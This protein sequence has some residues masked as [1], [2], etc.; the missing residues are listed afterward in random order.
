MYQICD[1]GPYTVQEG[2]Y[3]GERH[4]Y[5][6]HRETGKQWISKDAGE[7][8]PT[9]FSFVVSMIEDGIL[10]FRADR[11]INSCDTRF[12]LPVERQPV[13]INSEFD[14]LCFIGD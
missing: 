6:T 7:V 1:V 3:R 8:N 10:V 4:I 11:T 2:L 14:A 12:W 9:H 5:V 13:I